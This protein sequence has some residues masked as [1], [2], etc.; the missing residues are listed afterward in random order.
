M[1]RYLAHSQDIARYHDVSQPLLDELISGGPDGCGVPFLVSDA[2]ADWPCMEKWSFEWLRQQFF[3]LEVS[4]S[5]SIDSE[6]QLR[7]KLGDYIDYILDEEQHRNPIPRGFIYANPDHA[8]SRPLE[9]QAVATPQYLVAWDLESIPHI[10]DDFPQPYF[11][12]DRNLLDTLLPEARE[13]LFNKH[14]WVFVGPKGSLSELHN[15]HDHVHTYIA[16]VTGRKHFILF[17]PAYAGELAETDHLGHTLSGTGVNPL[18]PDLSRFPTFHSIPCYEC[19]L[20]PG[21]LLFL[22]AS[23]LHWAQGLEAGITVSKDSVDRLNFGAWF[24]SMFVDKLPN[25]MLR[26]INKSPQSINAKARQWI[27]AANASH[28]TEDLQYILER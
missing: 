12:K 11:M 22:P 17:S 16:Q 19:T 14:T 7:G 28:L 26:I 20:E 3:D 8:K 1:G 15:D 5:A 4:T 18:A 13:T 2:T 6:I 23:W 24:Q 21:D 25:Y 9:T 10:A 27:E